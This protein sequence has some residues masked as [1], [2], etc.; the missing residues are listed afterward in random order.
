[1]PEPQPLLKIN[2][3]VWPG[4]SIAVAFFQYLITV[5]ETM[6]QENIDE[7]DRIGIRL[8]DAMTRFLEKP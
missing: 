7:A 1:M 5:R 6:S 2:A 8:M 4:E 3:S